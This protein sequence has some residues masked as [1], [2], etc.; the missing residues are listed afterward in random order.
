[1]TIILFKINKEKFVRR[2]SSVGYNMETIQN[3]K[4]NPNFHL[5][6]SL[7]L[8]SREGSSEYYTNIT[9]DETDTVPSN[10]QQLKVNANP[11]MDFMTDTFCSRNHVIA[12]LAPFPFAIYSQF[13]DRKTYHSLRDDL[14]KLSCEVGDTFANCFFPLTFI[15]SGTSFTNNLQK[16]NSS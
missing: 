3:R 11:F 15:V 14:S 12:D 5:S 16:N 4:T 10:I 6:S 2:L 7:S 1:M 13:W 9:T 8:H